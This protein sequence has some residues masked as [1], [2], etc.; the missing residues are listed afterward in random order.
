MRTETNPGKNH[1]VPGKSQV[2][3]TATNPGKNHQVPGKS[4][5]LRNVDECKRL[6]NLNLKENNNENEQIM[7]LYYDGVL[8]PRKDQLKKDEHERKM[9]LQYQ[10]RKKVCTLRRK[11]ITRY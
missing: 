4:Q 5:V 9:K 8:K 7:K 1:Q 11:R 6:L 2:M 3:R 10:Q